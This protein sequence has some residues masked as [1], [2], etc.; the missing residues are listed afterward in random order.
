MADFTGPSKRFV[1]LI[2]I[3][4]I[5]P[6]KCS[7]TWIHIGT[8]LQ[9]VTTGLLLFFLCHCW[10]FIDQSSNQLQ[11]ASHYSPVVLWCAHRWKIYDCV[12]VCV[13]VT[14]NV[15]LKEL[16]DIYIYI[17]V[18]VCIYIYIYYLCVSSL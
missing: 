13:C 8:L 1:H 11:A 16:F 3:W 12:C 6:A 18:C 17:C 2:Q 14:C 9:A 5:V 15:C 10:L 7:E 4:S